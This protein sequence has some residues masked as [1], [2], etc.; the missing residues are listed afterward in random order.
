MF[1]IWDLLA[2][3]FE[4]Y[5]SAIAAL[6]LLVFCLWAMVRSWP[7]WVRAAMTAGSLL[8]IFL[9]LRGMY[10]EYYLIMLG[11]EDDSEAELAFKIIRTSLSDRQII[12]ILSDGRKDNNEQFYVALMAAERGLEA[13]NAKHIGQP[14]FFSTNSY[15]KFAYEL[16]YPI[17]YKKFLELYQETKGRKPSK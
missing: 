5:L 1:D 14:D 16:I 12:R 9:L 6:G 4:K 10:V 13:P 15:T 7:S 3:L 2:M 8:C 11:E 17:T